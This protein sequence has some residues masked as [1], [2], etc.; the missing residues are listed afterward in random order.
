MNSTLQLLSTPSSRTFVSGIERQR[1]AWL[2]SNTRI[3]AVVER[4]QRNVMRA[5][6][7]FHLRRRPAR[8]RT[9]LPHCRRL[10]DSERL[11]FLQA[12]ARG[13]LLASK[14]CEPRVVA[15]QR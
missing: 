4:Q 15:A 14:P 6:V 1:R 7:L 13:R 8:E 2:A 9:D 3:P 5:R 10:A 12:R 11:N